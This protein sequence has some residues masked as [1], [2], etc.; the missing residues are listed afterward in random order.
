MSNGSISTSSYGDFPVVN[1]VGLHTVT[2][3]CE[4]VTFELWPGAIDLYW[5]AGNSTTYP[6]TLRFCVGIAVT[7][8]PLTGYKDCR[9]IRRA[10]AVTKPDITSGLGCCDGPSDLHCSVTV[11]PPPNFNWYYNGVKIQVLLEI[12]TIDTGYKNTIGIRE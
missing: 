12:D 7:E 1:A 10:E 8:S 11:F 3:P 2:S 4:F 5:K 9:D 6:D